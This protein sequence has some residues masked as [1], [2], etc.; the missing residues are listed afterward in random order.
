MQI[1]DDK[2]DQELLESVIAE[3]A[4]ARAE[5]RCAEEDIK[6]IASRTGFL[7]VLANELINRQKG[8]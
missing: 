5:M 4:K 8:Q 7:L 6:K 2:T 1:L 3:L